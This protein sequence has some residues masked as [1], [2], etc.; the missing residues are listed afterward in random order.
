MTYTYHPGTSKIKDISD[1]A[2]KKEEGYPAYDVSEADYLYDDNGNMTYDPS[3]KVSI[4]YNHL[5]LPDS[6]IFDDGRIIANLYDHGGNKLAQSQILADGSL[7]ERRD[8]IANLELVSGELQVIH[9]DQGRVVKQDGPSILVLTDT[10]RHKNV[11]FYANEILTSNVI[12]EG[13]DV[14]FEARDSISMRPGFF[15]N[16]DGS[17]YLAQIDTIPPDTNWRW[18]YY[19]KDHLG[20]IRI[21]FA[22]LNHD[23]NITVSL[24]ADNE[25]LEE[26]HYYPFGMKHDGPWLRRK[27]LGLANKYNYNGKEEMPFTGYLYYGARVYDAGIARWNSVDPLSEIIPGYSSYAY[28]FN[29]PISYDDPTGMMG[30]NIASTHVDTRGMPIHHYNDGDD[31]IYV[32]D[33][34]TTKDDLDAAISKGSSRGGDLILGNGSRARALESYSVAQLNI[35]Q[36]YQDGDIDA[37]EYQMKLEGLDK[38][39]GG[40]GSLLLNKRKWDLASY[41]PWFVWLKWT[42]AAKGV[43][44]G[45]YTFTKSAAKH[46]DDIVT[47]NGWVNGGPARPYMNS[48]LTIKEIMATGKGI[49]DATAKGALNFKVPGTFRGSNGT[50]ELVVDPV[51]NHIYHFNF[52]H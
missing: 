7:A 22:D 19:I 48:P 38:D 20:N 52:V 39:Y 8:Y 23:G 13:S 41:V 46:F 18:E 29:N 4:I 42:R 21:S 28:V 25:I 35:V 43:T 24:G 11:Y 31:N 45:G 3:R 6:L 1:D 37:F 40:M 33:V 36:M 27:N 15:V 32:H 47:K 44:Q 14:T 12:L 26:N 17:K 50:W 2:A 34:G 10:I 16:D 5:N 49:P 51:K 9:H 30:R